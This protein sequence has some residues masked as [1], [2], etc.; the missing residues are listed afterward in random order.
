MMNTIAIS[1][2]HLP[3]QVWWHT[4]VTIIV[5]TSQR[6]GSGPEQVKFFYGHVILLIV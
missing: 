5:L 3:G 4:A 1:S 2:R 6:W